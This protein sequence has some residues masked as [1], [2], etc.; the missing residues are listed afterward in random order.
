MQH[1]T[2]GPQTDERAAVANDPTPDESD[3]DVRDEIKTKTAPTEP[4]CRAGVDHETRA[5]AHHR[6]QSC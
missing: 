2:V 1:E 6:A 4:G 3:K 5:W